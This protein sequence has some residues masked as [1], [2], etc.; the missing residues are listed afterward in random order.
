[1][2]FINPILLW[3]MAAIA[4]P[5]LIHLF[6]NRRIQPVVW[7]AM[8]FLQSALKKRQKRIHMEDVLLLLLRCL[9][10][11]LLALA[12]ARPVFRSGGGGGF[13]RG[14]EIAIIAIDNSY[15]MGQSDGGATR[16]DEARQVAGQVV[17]SLPQGSSVAVIL[18]S[19]VVRAVIPEPTYDLNLA[20]K[21]IRDA[22]LSDRSTDVPQALKYALETLERHNGGLQRVYLITD[23]QAT[24][25]KQFAEIE[26]QLRK[27]EVKTRV[28]LVGNPEEH[29][30]CVS[31]LQLASSIASVGEAAQFDV[32]VSNF[33]TSEVKDVAV[34]ISV[35][36]EPPSDEGLIE[37]IPGGGSKRLALYTKFRTAGYHTVT[38]QINGDHLPADD[39]RTIALRANDDVRVL[40]VSGDT[41]P[42]PTEN[43]LF[44]LRNALTPVPQSAREE[45]FIKTKTIN[46][47]ELEGMKLSDYEAVVLANVPDIT[48][49]ALDALGAYLDRGGGLVIFPGARTSVPF[50]NDN[51]G[52]RLGFLPATLGA[53][54]GKPDQQEKFFTL[55]AKGYTHPMVSIWSD[56]NAGTLATA[57]FYSAFELKPET[58]HTAQAGEPQIVLKYNDGT[59]AVMERTWGRGRVILFSSSAN[60]AWND[61]PLHPA[62]LPLVDRALGSILMRQDAR[63]NIPV[64]STFEFVC[65]PDWASKDAVVAWSGARKETSS[66]RRIGMVDNVPLLRFDDT[67]K[68]GAYDATIK[69]DP[70]TVVRFAAQFDP[71]ES[72]LGNITK[73]QLDSLPPATVQVIR[74]TQ[75][76]HLDEQIAK[77]R[78][79]S[80]FWTTLAM[81][82]IIVACVE[83]ALAGKFSAA[84]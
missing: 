21:I 47:T 41:S 74:W 76:T 79:G 59:P 9:L 53:Q 78:G 13:A 38:G 75:N 73:S 2:T 16:F 3:G 26:K 22:T 34:R 43:A 11:I 66:L 56:P 35:D 81:L 82:V 63:L 69:T 68:A 14:S 54:R 58:G 32:E 6:M 20:G 48:R 12:L 72:K 30:L 84:K 83:I 50:Y 60:T 33:G 51:L 49:V 45:Y 44:Y 36:D 23:G 4:A 5:I 15:S 57:H 46:F 24:G 19:D 31:G 17:N 71:E 25:W 42:E 40:L 8:R 61:L 70:P 27:P 10:L 67:D 18:F 52:K 65:D 1:M 64:G 37:K 62:Y 80:E 28:I 77:E 7:A 55:Q 29:N 39:R